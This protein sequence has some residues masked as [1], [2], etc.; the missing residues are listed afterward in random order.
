[1]DNYLEI[2]NHRHACRNFDANSQLTSAEREFILDCAR[3]SPSSFG[4]EPWHFLVIT[5][6]KLRQE[7]LSACWQQPQIQDADFIVVI[8]NYLPHNFLGDTPFLQQRIMRDKNITTADQYHARLS[9]IINYLAAQNTNDWTKRQCYIALSNL[10][11]GAASLGIDSC[12]LEGFLP[13]AVKKILSPHV[14]FFNFDITVLAAF[15]R[16][17]NNDNIRP[18]TREPLT[19]IVSYIY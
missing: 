10:L 8:L 19:A 15:G 2:L 12:P 6:T 3:L 4:L 14:D 11:N 16:R 17:L 5:N 13:E 7:L 9:R 18:K 1:M